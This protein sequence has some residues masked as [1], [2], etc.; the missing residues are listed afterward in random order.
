MSVYKVRNKWY[1]YIT[2]PDGTRY[3][4]SVGT[5]KQ[6]EQHEKQ[7]IAAIVQDKWE[8]HKMK[9]VSFSDLAAEYL[10][11]AK[12]NKAASSF[13]SDRCRIELHLLPYFGDIPIKRMTLSMAGVSMKEI[14]ELMGHLSFETTLQYAHLSDDHVKRQV[15]KLPY[16]DGWNGARYNRAIISINA[17]ALQKKESAVNTHGA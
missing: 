14:Q 17:D 16:A 12:A 5:K 11:Y 3:R 13:K 15:T 1:V 4:K 9:D 6:A 7:M 8:I 2:F 10:E